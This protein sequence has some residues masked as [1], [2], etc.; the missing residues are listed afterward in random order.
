[1]SIQGDTR[2]ISNLFSAMEKRVLAMRRACGRTSDEGSQSEDDSDYRK[3]PHSNTSPGGEEREHTNQ[4]KEATMVQPPSS[5]AGEGEGEL[6]SDTKQSEVNE[7]VP[8]GDQ[9]PD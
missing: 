8:Q 2:N 1:M 7:G 9:Q 5:V 4:V 6:E 3:M